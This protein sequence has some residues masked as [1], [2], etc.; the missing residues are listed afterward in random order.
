MRNCIQKING[1]AEWCCCNCCIC[2]VL[3][4]MQEEGNLTCGKIGGCCIISSV[5]L[6]T[7]MINEEEI[8]SK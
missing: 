8:I 2:G 7:N 3:Y 6:I 4:H 1:C 5:V